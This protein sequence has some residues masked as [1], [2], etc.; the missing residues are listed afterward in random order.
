TLCTDEDKR[1]AFITHLLALAEAMR[2]VITMRA[3]FWG[4]CAP[5]RDLTAVMQA[6]MENIPPMNTAEL[7]SAMEQQARAVGLRFEAD[8]SHTI[9][10]DVRGEPGA[11]P[12]LQHALLEMWKRRHGRWL[13]AEEYR[14]LGG[15]QQAISRT[16]DTIYAGLSSEERERMRDVFLRLTRLDEEAVPGEERRDTRRRVWFEEL[17]PA[18]TDPAPTRKLVQELADARLVVTSVNEVTEAEEVEVAHEALIRYWSRL[19]G[20]L[21]EDRDLL[22]LREGIRQA[23]QE[24]QTS[25]DEERESLLVH[26][27]ARLEDIEALVRQGRLRLNEQE[28]R[29]VEAC[30]TLREAERAREEEQRQRELKAAQDLAEEQRRRAEEQAQA[31]GRLR[32]R[33]IVLAVVALLAVVAALFAFYAKVTADQQRDLAESRLSAK[34]ALVASPLANTLDLRLLLGAGAFQVRETPR[35][36]S[37]LQMVMQSSPHLI[38]FLHGH[39]GDVWSV[40]FSPDGQTLASGSKDGTIVLWDMAARRPLGEPLRGHEASVRSLAF[41]PDGQTLASGGE[42]TAIILW[43]VTVRQQLGNPI[44][45]HE[46]SVRS[47]AFS[48]DGKTLASGSRDGTVVLWNLMARRPLGEPLQGH[49]AT[50]WSLAFS[51]DGRMLASG[52]EDDTI[53]LWDI[54]ARESLGGP[55]RGH[56]ATVWSVAFSPDGQT[57]AS[58][59]R[60]GTIILWDVGTR[61]LR[62][63]PIEMAEGSVTSVAFSPDG[64]ALATG[65]RNGAITLVD[66]ATSEWLGDLQVRKSPVWSV[67]FSPDSR[68]LASGHRDG[69][70]ILWDVT[71]RS[72]PR[73]DPES[74]GCDMAI[75]SGDQTLV[76]LAAP[77]PLGDRL[78][79]NMGEVCDV[80]LSPDGHILASAIEDGTIILWD[81]DTQVPLGHSLK[82]HTAP[83]LGMAFSLDGETLTSVSRDGIIIVWSVETHQ[84]LVDSQEVPVDEGGASSVAFSEDGRKLALGTWDGTIV[85]WDVAKGEQ[86]G[87]LEPH[88]DHSSVSSVTFSPDAQTLG[89][90]YD[91]GTI[92]LWNLAQSSPSVGPIQSQRGSVLSLAFSP[93]GR[94]FASGDSVGA[95]LWDA[96]TGTRL[97][98]PLEYDQ[99]SVTSAVFSHDGQVLASGSDGGTIILWDVATGKPLYR[100]PFGGW[101]WG[102]EY[103]VLSMAFSPNQNLLASGND[104]GTVILWD[105]DPKSWPARACRMANRNLTQEEW[106]EFFGT[107]TRYQCTCPDLPPGDGAPSNA[108]TGTNNQ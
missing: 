42:D 87:S 44:L 80:A 12:L 18:G 84:P 4:D 99:E 41:S 16:A 10:D 66:V 63:S 31:A 78:R 47:L 45:G 17:V 54:T 23:T 102:L 64:K 52:G 8:L 9:L 95:V 51:P 50:V 107:E 86:I 101:L 85:L 75:L 20:W 22:R 82:G 26:R 79:S 106:N 83:A 104:D 70:V 98:A 81:A 91:D 56:E 3:D 39:A 96:A 59:D 93:D 13:R 73:G 89:S 29:Y 105:L 7:R 76:A 94:T 108:C 60:G 49:E 32:Q 74:A 1:R 15:V 5:H 38:S 36:R 24:W 43:D 58:G 69:T 68:T 14:A 11:M 19:R 53:I 6:H 37:A 65:K 72:S 2:V 30:V 103:R 34:L 27:G 97:V 90:G 67:A 28:Q 71:T 40:A 62:G 25:P 88:E 92:L 33:A 55:L 21:D 61:R 48:P 46:A 57:L 77:A 35:A 100:D